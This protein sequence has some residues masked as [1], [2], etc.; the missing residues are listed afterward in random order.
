MEKL[1]PEAPPVLGMSLVSSMH[2]LSYSAAEETIVPKQIHN[3]EEETQSYP[4]SSLDTQTPKA[5]PTH[6]HL[7]AC[8]VHVLAAK[9]KRALAGAQKAWVLFSL[10]ETQNNLQVVSLGSVDTRVSKGL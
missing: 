9:L 7:Y 6:T 10:K 8:S 3:G 5:P 2:R 4:E 1:H